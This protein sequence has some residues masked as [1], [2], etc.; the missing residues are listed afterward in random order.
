V[1]CPTCKGVV[2]IVEHE[3]IELDYCIECHGV[4]FDAGELDL[5]LDRLALDGAAFTMEEII[6][7]PE[8]QVAEK[9]RACPVCRKKMKKVIIGSDPEVLIDIC[10][11][12]HG[13]WFDG[14]ELSQVI[15]QL[16]N[17]GVPPTDKQGRILS[18]LE[19]AFKATE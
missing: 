4:W 16:I 19:E 15:R 3:R 10:Q 8:K 17:K 9:K 5:L 14:G 2:I 18:F 12:G 1:D 13:I 7:L 11:R 6:S